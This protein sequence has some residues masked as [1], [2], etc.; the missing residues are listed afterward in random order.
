MHHML[1]IFDKNLLK[2]ETSISNVRYRRKVRESNGGRGAKLRG[3]PSLSELRPGMR[4]CV[5]R[6]RRCVRG[7][8]V[9]SVRRASDRLPA[10]AWPEHDSS[11][12]SRLHN[13]QKW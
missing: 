13:P 9:A 2:K 10:A 3:L 11:G 12:V 7:Q 8:S 4:A 1:G 5:A 6:C